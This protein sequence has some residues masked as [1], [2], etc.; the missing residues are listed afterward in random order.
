MSSVLQWP[1]GAVRGI[2]SGK[3]PGISE[4]VSLI[5]LLRLDPSIALGVMVN[6]RQLSLDELRAQNNVLWPRYR[7]YL[8]GS[9]E[10]TSWQNRTNSGSYDVDD[11]GWWLRRIY[12]HVQAAEDKL[13][14][15]PRVEVRPD[16]TKWAI[17]LCLGHAFI[18]LDQMALMIDVN[19]AHSLRT[20]SAY[21]SEYG[22]PLVTFRV[23]RQATIEAIGEACEGPGD[24]IRSL[25]FLVGEGP[26]RLL[27]ELV[28]AIDRVAHSI[29]SPLSSAVQY[30]FNQHSWA[31][32]S[33][34]RLQGS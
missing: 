11:P 16:A 6:T 32:G 20:H 3:F 28:L 1:V 24:I 33:N 14:L 25:T 5:R 13:K 23:L 26:E 15:A 7:D 21:I 17:A 19:L 34:A 22:Y 30:V 8:G 4:A 12:H 31:V 9:R 27:A 18:A 29:P 10:P 2:E